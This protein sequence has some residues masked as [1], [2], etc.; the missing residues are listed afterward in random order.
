ME[1]MAKMKKKNYEKKAKNIQN[2]KY[3]NFII[4]RMVLEFNFPVNE[5]SSVELFHFLFSP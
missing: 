2:I 4:C 5:F 1:R 3:S